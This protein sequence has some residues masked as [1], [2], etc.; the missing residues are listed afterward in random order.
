MLSVKLLEGQSS[1]FSHA[2]RRVELH[3]F[4]YIRRI[5]KTSKIFFFLSE[6]PVIKFHLTGRDF[7]NEGK[8]MRNRKTLTVLEFAELHLEL[9]SG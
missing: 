3:V 5:N 8:V 7:D 1:T 9:S 6:W 4:R 2:E